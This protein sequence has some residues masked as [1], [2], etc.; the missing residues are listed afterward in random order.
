LGAFSS[1]PRSPYLDPQSLPKKAECVRLNQ[2]NRAVYLALLLG[3]AIIMASIL[4]NGQGADDF[5]ALARIQRRIPLGVP[6]KLWRKAI[7]A[8][9]PMTEQKIALGE[10][11]YFDK[12]LSLDGTVSCATCHDP[13]NAFTDHSPVAVGV[14]GRVGTRSAP[15]ILNSAFNGLEFWD[16]RASS[17]EEQAKQPLINPAEMGMKDHKAVVDRVSSIPEYR[18]EF[19]RI[20]RREGITIDTIVKAIA[21]FERI[22][23][24]GN[25]PFDR[26]VAGEKEA[27]S[28]A[29]ERGLELFKGKARC[30]ECHTFTASYP[31]FTDFK[32]HNTGVAT[33]GERFERLDSLALEIK[34]TTRGGTALG[35]LAHSEKFSDLGRYLV[36]RQLPDLAAFKTPTLRDIELTTPYMHDG[37]EKT[38]LDV[39]K[40][41]NKGGEPNAYRDKL[42]Q[43][44]GL[45]D[46]EMSNL[47]E[48]MRALT[49]DDVLRQAQRVR[50]QTRSAEKL[51]TNQRKP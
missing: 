9:N 25:S 15:T 20:F 45:T 26:F 30:T 47:V 5:V 14:G 38:L 22:Q 12:R 42:M 2:V 4:A 44:L 51:P 24:S 1:N 50:P 41:Y 6:A 23:L 40:F 31:F 48:F 18:K 21:A 13:A 39:V 27:I 28:A 35:T 32:F 3:A 33:R 10:K 49:S 19:E 36:T 8:N 11:L 17:L 37:S 29:Q 7:P 43:P 34:N 46:Q 16:G